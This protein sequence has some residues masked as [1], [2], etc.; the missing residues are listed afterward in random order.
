MD[1]KLVYSR[2]ETQNK[3]N[4]THDFFV[5]FVSWMGW[6]EKPISALVSNEDLENKDDEWFQ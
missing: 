3:K 4:L 2:C 6:S 1:T 5:L